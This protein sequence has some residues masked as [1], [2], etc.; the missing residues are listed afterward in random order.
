MNDSKRD[1]WLAGLALAAVLL[2]TSPA[3]AAPPVADTAVAEATATGG[4]AER[5]AGAVAD[6]WQRVAAAAGVSVAAP[7]QPV[8]PVEPDDGS[9]TLLA[10]S[11]KEP[12]GPSLDP[13]GHY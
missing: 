10:S 11:D 3:L 7:P 9:D 4:W 13:N 2:V 12:S 8:E 6:L 1:R 5:W